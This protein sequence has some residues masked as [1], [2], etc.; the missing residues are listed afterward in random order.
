LAR[1]CRNPG[2]GRGNAE[3]LSTEHVPRAPRINARIAGTRPAGEIH[4][5]TTA[6]TTRTRSRGPT[7]RWSVTRPAS[8][9]PSRGSSSRGAA[10][11]TS[12]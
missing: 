5:E 3:A 10:R 1:S 12:T 8:S 9:T 11:S 6:A 7:G 4:V 2:C